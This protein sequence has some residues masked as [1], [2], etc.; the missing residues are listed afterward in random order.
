MDSMISRGWSRQTEISLGLS[1]EE[2]TACCCLHRSSVR[3]HFLVAI[4]REVEVEGW[5]RVETI[6]A[7]ARAEDIGVS[8]SSAVVEAR[9]R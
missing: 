9:E 1:I 4:D 2:Q 3:Y 5:M 6:N 7:A 8:S